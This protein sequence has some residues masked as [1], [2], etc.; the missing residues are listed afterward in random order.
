MGWIKRNLFFVIGGAVALLLLGGAGY[1]IYQGWT[2]N[3]DASDKLNEIYGTLNNLHQQKPAPGSGKV[4]NTKIAKEQTQQLRDWINHAAVYFQ[5]IAAI[6]AGDVTSEAYASSLRR[7][8]DSLQ[9]AADAANVTLPPKY[10]F[11]FSAQRPL[12]KF[13]AGSLPALAVQLGEVKAIAETI[14]SAQVNAL[15]SIQRTRVSDDDAAGPPADYIDDHS[16]T[17]DLAIITPYVVTFRCF[18]PELARVLAAF[19]SS[20]NSFLIKAI[21]IQPASAAAANPGDAGLAVPGGMP[22]MPMP[23]RFPGGEFGLPPGGMPPTATP[24]PQP[25]VGKGGLP[26]VLKEQ[27]LSISMLLELVKLSPKG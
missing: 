1:Y 26:V 23:G 17:N 18:T 11:S 16:V 27:L 24:T 9:H 6:P 10:D 15:D 19:A 13:A 8:I 14:F 3:S 12:V 7:T 20:S 21:N 4:D 25:V 5:P 2:S 22:G